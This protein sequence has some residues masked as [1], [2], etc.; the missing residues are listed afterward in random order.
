MHSLLQ[1]PRNHLNLLVFAMIPR[2]VEFTTGV[3]SGLLQSATDECASTGHRS[4]VPPATIGLSGQL[5][6]KT[7]NL[8]Y[9][10]ET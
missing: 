5:N 10:T 2:P 6:I 8:Q 1:C 4:T 9:D 7:G 3:A